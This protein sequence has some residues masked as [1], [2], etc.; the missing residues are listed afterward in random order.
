MRNLKSEFLLDPSIIFLNHGSFG[1]CPRAVFEVYQDWQRQLEHQPVEFLSRRAPD[2][3]AHAREELANYL[4]VESDEIV[5]FP[6]PTTALN[7]VARNLDLQPG[8]EILTT[9]HEYGAMDR[10]WRFIC[11]ETGAKYIQQNVSLPVSTKGEFI[12]KLWDGVTPKTKIIFL[13]HISSPTALIFP[14]ILWSLPQMDVR[15]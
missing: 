15:T 9:N 8:D 4:N 13:S 11:K 7:M 1:A 3:L 6:N 2:L 12:E 10:T 14:V 5:Y